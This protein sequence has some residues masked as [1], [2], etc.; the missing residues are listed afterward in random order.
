MSKASNCRT[1]RIH[2]SGRACDGV[3]PGRRLAHPARISDTPPGA[4]QRVLAAQ[5]AARLQ[6]A[7]D[8]HLGYE[9]GERPP[10]PAGATSQRLI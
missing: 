2:R 8:D 6:A 5:T 1:G 7:L 9:K 3:H 10:F 4:K